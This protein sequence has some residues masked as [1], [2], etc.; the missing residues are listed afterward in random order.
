M[1][2]RSAISGVF[3]FGGG[4]KYRP[5]HPLAFRRLMNIYEQTLL[6]LDACNLSGL[7]HSYRRLNT[8]VCRQRD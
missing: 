3:S 2:P 5:S 1:P 7:A 4:N 6:M 8:R